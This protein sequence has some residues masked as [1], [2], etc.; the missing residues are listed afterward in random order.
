M[1]QLGITLTTPLNML[2]EF[3]DRSS[4]MVLQRNRMILVSMSTVRTLDITKLFTDIGPVLLTDH[5]HDDYYSLVEQVMS[6]DTTVP[7]S[8]LHPCNSLLF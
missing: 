6:T 3:L 8:Y 5:F 1:A 2:L 7:V 4:S